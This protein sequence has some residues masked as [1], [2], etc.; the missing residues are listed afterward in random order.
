MFF[1]CFCFLLLARP[2]SF[3]IFGGGQRFYF[4]ELSDLSTEPDL[5]IF[6]SCFSRVFWK[7]LFHFE[8]K[9]NQTK[10]NPNPPPPNKKKEKKKRKTAKRELARGDENNS[11][12]TAQEIE[13]AINNNNN[14]EMNL[15]F[16]HCSMRFCDGEV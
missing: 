2:G 6:P 8:G 15:R 13:S 16:H 14:P 1:L 3:H 10:K 11:I 7:L 4:R 5:Y 9:Y 12:K